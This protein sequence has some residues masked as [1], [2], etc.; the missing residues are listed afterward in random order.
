MS[1]IGEKNYLISGVAQEST[2]NE[3]KDLVQNI[4]PGDAKESS[5]QN[6]KTEMNNV[7]NW[8]AKVGTGITLASKTTAT[9]QIQTSANTNATITLLTVDIPES[10]TYKWEINNIF[11]GNSK[12][13]GDINTG[14]SISIQLCRYGARYG[15][16]NYSNMKAYVSTNVSVASGSCSSGILSS[17]S[18]YFHAHKGERILLKVSAHH[19][20]STSTTKYAHVSA[21]SAYIKYTKQFV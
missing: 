15:V 16:D 18:G 20:G 10:G 4:K 17:K 6:I 19:G 8:Y 9:S 12:K 3:I 1:D 5:V 11:G 13:Q 14:D 21:D 2:S 7:K